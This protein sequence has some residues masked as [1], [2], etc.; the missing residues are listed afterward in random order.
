MATAVQARLF[1]RRGQGTEVGA[2]EDL[3]DGDRLPGCDADVRQPV[4]QLEGGEDV[5]L[6]VEVAGNVGAREPEF[7][8]CKQDPAQRVDR[9]DHDAG[10]RVGWTEPGPVV[11]L[12]CDREVVAEEV[13]D[14]AGERGVGFHA[15]EVMPAP[16]V[17]FRAGGPAVDPALC[18]P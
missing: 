2:P 14:D 3:G 13:A 1:G 8:G 16:A 7:A 18:T 6:D 15:R 11:P 17:P 10:R 9:P 12:E 5:A 4:A